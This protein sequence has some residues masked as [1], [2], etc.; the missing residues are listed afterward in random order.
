MRRAFTFAAGLVAG[1]LIVGG[2]LAVL[3]DGAGTP[4]RCSIDD[5]G[6]LSCPGLALKETTPSTDSTT[7]DSSTPPTT[8]SPQPPPSSSSPTTAAPTTDPAPTT[9]STAA[10]TT[11]TS[12]TTSTTSPAPPS[13]TPAASGQFFEDFSTPGS[14]LARFDHGWSGEVNAGAAFNP[15]ENRND[16]PGDH[17]MA[18]CGNP[19]TM[20]R[21]IHVSASPRNVEQAFYQCAPG[22][23][24]AAAHLMTSVNTE[25]YVTAWFSPKQ[26]FT[27]VHRVCWDQ[28]ITDLGGGK[29]VIVNF[30]TPAEYQGQT[31]LG[32]TSP[33]FPPSAGPSSPQGDARNGVKVFEDQLSSYTNGVFRGGVDGVA[34]TADKAA[35]FKHCVVDNDNGTL[36]VSIA[37]P[38]GATVSRTVPGNIPDG[39]IRVEFADDSYNPDK[40][41]TQNAT[42]TIACPRYVDPAGNVWPNANGAEAPNHTYGLTWHWDN[43]EVA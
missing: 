3:A 2:G 5:T 32:Y 10:S 27:N 7:P 6:T 34:P 35:R 22:G 4:V 8:S 33:D 12:S 43:I 40:H 24:N 38:S 16:W 42:P 15:P 17:D 1:A 39:P 11:S 41:C 9:S 26:V 18:T 28:N 21:T 37:Q 25:G 20:S 29:W 14:F 36:T 30:L 19:M 13:T 23:S 31:D